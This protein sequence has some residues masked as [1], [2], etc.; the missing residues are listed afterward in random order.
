VF[1]QREVNF[2]RCICQAF[3][4]YLSSTRGLESKLIIPVAP[5]KHPSSEDGAT[6]SRR[7]TRYTVRKSDTVQTVADN[8]GVP[9]AM[10][11]RWNHLK[12]NSLYGHHVLYVHLPVAPSICEE[13]HTASNPKTRK[14]LHETV[15]SGAVRHKVQRG[16]TLYSIAKSHNTTVAA[17]K[18]SNG[19]LVSLRPGMILVITPPSQ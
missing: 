14:D 16:E 13:S 11:R 15:A 4:H 2:S 1:G 9:A 5:G 19:N 7:A 18:Q 12:G 17:L 8:F 10:V 6:Y 3:P